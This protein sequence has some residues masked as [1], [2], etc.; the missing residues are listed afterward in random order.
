MLLP[1]QNLVEQFERLPGVGPRTAR[2]LA[3]HVIGLSDGEVEAFAEA[4]RMAKSSLRLCDA[5]R[6]L[7]VDE[8]CTICSDERRNARV[9]CVVESSK[10]LLAIERLGVYDGRYFVL[11]G[12]LSPVN[13]VTPEDL[14][15]GDLSH[16]VQTRD[17]DEVIVATAPTL[18]GDA[19]ALYIAG[20]LRGRVGAVT[21]LA[22]G[23]PLGADLEFTD[24]VTLSHAL[25]GRTV[26]NA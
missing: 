17:V 20:L 25:H 12:A 1:L 19:T 6:N 4:L 5:C 9:I 11:H 24:D 15:I 16:T 26:L 2:R 14:H 8:L 18:E 22:Y 23:V 3:F 21:R 13:N 7:S 10:D